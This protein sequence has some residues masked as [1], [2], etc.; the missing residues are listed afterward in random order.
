MAVSSR[1]GIAGSVS[2]GCVEGAVVEAALEVLKG[3]PARLL[4]FGVAD[5][6]A[7]GVGLACGG[8]IEVFVTKLEEDTYHRLRTGIQDGEAPVLATQIVGPEQD[9]GR[10]LIWTGRPPMRS[11]RFYVSRT[12]SC[13]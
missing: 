7:W 2:G 3:A 8:S 13:P 4:Q 1:S 11:R 6:T 12:P 5:E 9:A 10:T